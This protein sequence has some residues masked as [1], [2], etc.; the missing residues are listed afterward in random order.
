MAERSD[1]RAFLAAAGAAALALGPGAAA[2]SA[3][4]RKKGAD[5]PG[6]L[7]ALLVAELHAAYAHGR[8][9]RLVLA[10]HNDEHAKAL[11]SLLDALGRKIPAA[12]SSPAQ[13]GPI[14]S[15]ATSGRRA[16]AIRLERALLD[17]CRQRLTDLGDPNM[18]RTVATIMAG[19]A[20]H[21]AQMSDF[22]E[23]PA[24]V[25]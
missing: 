23:L 14:A 1:R 2:A 8:T 21:L 10:R 12:P 13:L 16:D 15:A 24:G 7:T 11:A 22:H 19:H 20:Q 3:L 18:V 4:D 25:P 17:L 6:A 9:G 5:E